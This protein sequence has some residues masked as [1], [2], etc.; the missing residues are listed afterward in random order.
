M[1]TMT[2]PSTA[3]SV[4]SSRGQRLRRLDGDIY[5]GEDDL[6][7]D[8]GVR[9]ILLRGQRLCRQDQFD[10]EVETTW[11]SAAPPATAL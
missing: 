10:G 6:A 7:I 9:E 11:Y 3:G 2:W 5:E 8:G 1:A 4:E